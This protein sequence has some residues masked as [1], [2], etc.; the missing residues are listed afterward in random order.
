MAVKRYIPLRGIRKHIAILKE[1]KLLKKNFSFLKF[2][3]KIGKLICYGHF[4]PSNYSPTFRYKIEWMPGFHPKVFPLS[5]KI[6]Y[7]DNIH[8]YKDGSLCLYYPKDFS[9]DCISSHLHETIIPW[10]HEWFLF[11]ELYL[12]KGYWL[13]PYV[14]HKKI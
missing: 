7:N 11:Y 14:D 5:P 9:Y 13:H 12:I 3:V 2:E 8:L 1:I 4:Q 6:T 10:T